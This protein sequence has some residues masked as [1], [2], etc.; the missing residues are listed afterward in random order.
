MMIGSHIVIETDHLIGT[1]E[2]IQKV[3]LEIE[4]TL[5]E[6]IM[7][8]E[9][10][11]VMNVIMID[12][13]NSITMVNMKGAGQVDLINHDIL[14]GMT[15]DQEDKNRVALE[16]LLAKDSLGM[17]HRVLFRKIYKAHRQAWRILLKY[18]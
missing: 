11:G 13:E 15:N 9:M 6:I 12:K 2:I 16:C 17:P 1:I 14:L 4:T 8:Q 18:I 3:D 7:T 5:T 10:K